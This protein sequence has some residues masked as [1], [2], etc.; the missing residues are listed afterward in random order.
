M[1]ALFLLLAAITQA[2][3]AAAERSKGVWVSA[4]HGSFPT[5]TKYQI[6]GKLPKSGDRVG[7]SFSMK[8]RGWEVTVEREGRAPVRLQVRSNERSP[9]HFNRVLLWASVDEQELRL[10]LP[11][12]EAQSDCFTN[13]DDVFASLYLIIPRAGPPEVHGSRFEN[14]EA[15]DEQ[16]RTARENGWLVLS[17]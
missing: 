2:P 8:E 12:G 9:V 11:Y 16:L 17:D 15:R 1:T 4:T 7:A 13:G 3:T 10:K 6:D 14:C 5:I